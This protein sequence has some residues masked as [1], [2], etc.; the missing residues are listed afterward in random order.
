[1]SG[2][3]YTILKKYVEENLEEELI[4]PSTS[5][6]SSAVLFVENPGGGLRLCVDYRALND[7]TI[8]NRYRIPRIYETLIFLGKAKF[9]KKIRS[10]ISLSSDEDDRLI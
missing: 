1:M 9:F 8:K 5:P 4:R 10:H 6:A 7:L 2:E 3:E